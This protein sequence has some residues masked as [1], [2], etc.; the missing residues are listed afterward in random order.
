MTFFEGA[1][2]LGALAWLPHLI[3]LIKEQVTRPKIRII[4][5]RTAEI[6]YTPL[7]PILNLRIAFSLRHRDIVISSIKMRLKHESGEERVL[8]WQGIVQRLAQMSTPEVG[9]IPWEK[10]HS[11]LAIK[12]TEK[13]VEE[14]LIRFQEDDYHTNKANYE[15]K[16]AKKLTYLKGRGE[17][18]PDEFLQ[19]EEM[20]DLVSFIKHWFNWKQG[21]YTVTFEIE[22]PEAFDLKDNIYE[23]PLDP[24]DIELL[25]ANKGLILFSYEDQLKFGKE[26]YQPQSINWNWVNPVF[27]KVTQTVV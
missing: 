24:L 2:I 8:S 7:G 25:E 23:F 10:E 6:G 21:K 16:V 4:T 19:T 12:L 17:Y 5:Q 1:A 26:G 9:L 20:K 18:D 27:K 3:K 15:N 11:V 14:R 13:E 22:S